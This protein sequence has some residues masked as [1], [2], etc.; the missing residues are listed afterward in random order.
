MLRIGRRDPPRDR[1]SQADDGTVDRDERVDVGV[2]Y[3][4]DA[5]TP[6]PHVHLTR[7]ARR[8]TVAAVQ[9]DEPHTHPP[10]AGV[11][12]G[13]PHARLGITPKLGRHVELV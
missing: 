12:D 4:H 1:L 6:Q 5:E 3:R 7:D 2:L 13:R 9:A 10:S 8:R 11:I